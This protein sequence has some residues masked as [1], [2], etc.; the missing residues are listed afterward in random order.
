MA[1]QKRTWA[2][3]HLDR[4]E[5]N[6]RALRRCAPGRKFAGIVKANA[7]GHGAVAVAK[8]L[9][10]LGADYLA[11]ACTD[12]ALEVR[13]AGIAMPILLLGS[14]D[15]ADTR[16]LLENNLTQTIYDPVMAEEFSRRAVE[17]GKRLRCHMKIDTGMSRLGIL[18]A[19]STDFSGIDT[20]ER[21]CRLP[22]LEWEG[23]FMHFADADTSPEYSQMQFDRYCRVLSEL[24]QRGITFPLRHT[25][26]GAATLKLEQARL[27]MIRPG[28]P[29]YGCYP[30]PST[31]ALIDLQPVM[32]L[33][34]RLISLRSLPK[35]TCISYGRTCTLERDSRIAVVP[36]G[37]AD[38]LPRLLSGKMEML[39]RGQRVRQIGRICMDMCML[40]V[41]DVPEAR[42]GDVVTVF[43]DG[44]PLQTLADTMGTI[45]YELM[46]GVA[47][48][49]P[50]IY[51]E[52]RADTCQ[53]R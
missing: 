15:P 11:V 3:I 39:V 34:T 6:Y 10:A 49:V 12:E 16:L 22:G 35:G 28:I 21:M 33:K 31:E 19:E 36:V 30:D 2:E 7:Y 48:R 18:C 32:E 52:S 51:L 27:D 14:V 50:R 40:D 29:L 53:N 20:V 43:G 1:E 25:C 44:V 46:C 5:Q 42:V 47:P 23:I 13:E 41:T 8:R 38:G 9:E 4:L 37:Y 24:E 17:L 45:T 26:A